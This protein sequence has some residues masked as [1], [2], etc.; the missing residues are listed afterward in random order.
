VETNEQKKEE[1]SYPVKAEKEPEEKAMACHVGQTSG[2]SCGEIKALSR[3]VGFGGGIFEEGL[4]EVGE[5]AAPTERLIGEGG[6]SGGP[7]LTIETNNE[8]LIEGT[9]VGVV[10]PTCVKVAKQKGR[11]FFTTEA[12]CLNLKVAELET[13]EGEWERKLRLIFQPL[14]QPV[15]GAGEGPM[16]AFELE[17]LTTANESRAKELEEEEEKGNP[18]ILP[19]PT[20]KAPLDFTATSGKAILESSGKSKIECKEDSA[21][22]EFTGFREGTSTIDFHGCKDTS[23]GAACESLGDTKETILTGGSVEL[24]ALEKESKL[25][26]GLE[27]APQELHLECGAV[28]VLIKGTTIGEV[29]GIENGKPTKIGTAIF[30]Q[31]KGKQAIVECRLTKKFCEG[32]K[33]M[34]EANFGKA[35]EEAGLETEE[36][37]TF[38]KEATFD[39]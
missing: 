13:N 1:T 24:V 28:L 31:E 30:K 26:L 19:T 3:M 23:L 32:K 39:F 38:A 8:A 17:L 4:A 20:S 14:T 5:P 37:L 6:D 2:E 18:V 15:P 27:F 35:F 16:E 33:F 34:L 10:T 7:W 36:K 22:G 12:N 9:H 29:G 11:Q 25:A 21:S